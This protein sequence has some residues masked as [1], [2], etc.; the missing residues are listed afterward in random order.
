MG[1]GVFA[2]IPGGDQNI[3]DYFAVGTMAAG[4][5]GGAMAGASVGNLRAAPLETSAG[6]LVGSLPLFLRTGDSTQGVV[7]DAIGFTALVSVA[8]AG[9][10]IGQPR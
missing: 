3:S 5:A 7:F 9:N 6:A 4:A 1:A 10:L 2:L 8:W